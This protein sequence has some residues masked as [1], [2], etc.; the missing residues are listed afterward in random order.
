[1]RI[2][3][4]RHLHATHLVAAGVD[5]RTAADRL[6]HADPGYMSRQYAHAVAAAQ[7]KAAEAPRA[8]MALPP[9]RRPR[10]R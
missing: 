1:M 9:R 6:G 8:L 5:W 4:L 3:D 2:Y 7:E 10:T